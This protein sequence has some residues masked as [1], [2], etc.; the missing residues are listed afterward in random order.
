MPATVILERYPAGF[1]APAS[2]ATGAPRRKRVYIFPTAQGWLYGLMLVMMLLGAINYNNSMAYMLCFLLAALGLVAMLHTHRNLSGLIIRAQK[3]APVHAGQE[4]RFP[5]RFD[6]RQGRAR[7]A[8]QIES[9]A[10]GQRWFSRPRPGPRI[11][12]SLKAGEQAT[13]ACPRM[14]NRRG[15]LPPG[16]LVISSCFPLGLF[17]AWAYF[18]PDMACVVYPRPRGHDRLPLADSARAAA[19]RG[20]KAGAED[21]AGLKKYR[22]GDAINAIAWKAFARGQG[23]LRKQFSGE[24]AGVVLLGWQSVADLD[25]IE[26]RLSQLCHWVLLAARSG[27]SYGLEIPGVNI[28]PASG[29]RHQARCLEQL[30]RYGQPAA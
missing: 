4:A 14:A 23:L 9:R 28:A 17:N 1:S 5:L 19:R 24:G 20:E 15:L 26:A 25:D 16:R 6:N 30:A 7:F 27:L 2:G 12:A 29:G 13:L 18:E 11:A 8:I 10:P 21:F 3:P 22:P